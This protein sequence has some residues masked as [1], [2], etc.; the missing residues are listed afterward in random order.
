M[1]L[2]YGIV[3]GKGYSPAPSHATCQSHDFTLPTG[4]SA[5]SQ[6][7]RVYVAPANGLTVKI[8]ASRGTDR[9][10]HEFVDLHF[11]AATS[12]LKTARRLA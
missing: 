5:R 10:V 4:V 1:A 8:V 12:S 11:F 6:T 9:S 3:G 7:V 2:F